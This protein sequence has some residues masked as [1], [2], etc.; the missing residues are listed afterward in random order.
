MVTTT[1]YAQSQDRLRD[2]D[3]ALLYITEC[4]LATVSDLAGRS[5]PPKYE[6][7][8]QINIAQVGIDWVAKFVTPGDEVGCG[9]VSNIIN[10]GITVQEWADR[11]IQ[12]R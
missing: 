9:R 11:Q 5:R 3:D 7:S 8:R 6:L 1:N 4:N 10:N 2:Q 12:K